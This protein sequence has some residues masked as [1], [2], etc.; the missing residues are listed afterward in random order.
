MSGTRVAAI[1]RQELRT[2]LASPAFLALLVVIAAVTMTLNP[3]GFVRGTAQAGPHAHVNSV[4]AATWI[5]T[6]STFLIY[7]FFASLMAGMGILRDDEERVS[8]MIHATPLTPAEYVAGKLAGVLSALG[9]AIAAHASLVVICLEIVPRLMPGPAPG[10]FDAWNHLLPLLA[11]VV[12]NVVFIAVVAFAAGERTRRPLAVHAV[13]VMLFLTVA[14]VFWQW[15]PAWLPT[16]VDHLLEMA[17]PSALRWLTRD[18]LAVDRGAAFYN[19]APLAFGTTFFVN[20]LIV[21]TVPVVLVLLSI[22]HVGNVARGRRARVSGD[23][24]AVAAGSS[25]EPHFEGFPRMEQRAPGFGSVVIEIA[26]REIR[27][28]FAQPAVLLLIP[29]A[30]LLVVQSAYSTGELLGAASIPTAGRIAV[31][32][33]E[34]LTAVVFLL[35]M[36]QSVESLHRERSIGLDSIYFS[37]PF[38][39]VSFLAGKSLAGAALGT[40]ILGASAVAS[41]TLMVMNGAAEVW[42]LALVWGV[43]LAPTFLVWIG[44]MLAVAAI[45]R[46]R[47]ATYAVGLTALALTLYGQQRGA[48]T[49]A[50]NWPLWGTLR[51]SDMGVFPLDAGALLMNRLL[52][53]ATAVFL[54]AIAVRQFGRVEPDLAGASGRFELRAIPTAVR[55]LG[56]FAIAPVLLVALI[57]WQVG[58]GF[59]GDAVNRANRAYWRE[60]VATFSGFEVP[61]LEHVSATIDLEPKHR[62]MRVAG[63]YLLVNRGARPVSRLPVTTGFSFRDIAWRVDGIAA[64]AVDRAGLHVIDLPAP[65]L[66]GESMRLGFSYRAVYPEGYSRNGGSLHAFI[67]P[68]G[69]LLSTIRGEFLPVLGF[70]H[71]IGIDAENRA[72]PASVAP[73]FW[74]G[75]LDPLDGLRPFD[76][77]LE[78]SVPAAYR[79][80]SVGKMTSEMTRGGRT[81]S[82]W[83]TD[84]PVV[85]LQLAAGRWNVRRDG[86]NAVYFHPGHD[87]NAGE[88]LRT[89]SL[90][91]AKFSEWFCPYPWEELRIHEVPD[92]ATIATSFPTNVS[93][94]ESAGF[95]LARDGNER[96]PFTI[97]AHEVAHQWWGNLLVPGEG[98][99]ADVLT[100]SLAQ[101]SALLLRE[102][103]EGRAGRIAFLSHLEASYQRSRSADAERPLA[104][105]IDDA[106]G[107]DAT[108]IHDKGP[109]VLWMLDHHLGRARMLA[110]LQELLRASRGSDDHPALHDLIA[111]LRRHSEYPAEFDSLV[112]QWVFDVIVPEFRI[113][114]ASVERVNGRWRVSAMVTNIGGGVVTADVALTGTSATQATRRSARFVPGGSHRMEWV[115]GFAP[116]R[117]VVDPDR[118]LLQLRRDRAAAELREISSSFEPTVRR[119]GMNVL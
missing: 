63:T 45:V 57:S 1:A 39:T 65:L 84:H 81:T 117:I 66:P 112:D 83:E 43:V 15:S 91:R 34:V 64:R 13:A 97:T 73:D 53:L 68:A 82:V 60:N 35:L 50:W 12:P 28:L 52:M 59:Q 48:M 5:L 118:M 21:V 76:A 37:L 41:W 6:L 100:E 80:T 22:R 31:G 69:A 92:I 47:S 115:V 29:L 23:G 19:V 114:E 62:R 4:Y 20:R 46:S 106:S 42:P 14:F 78:I 89:L 74:K 109:W 70:V 102:H 95:L 18:L 27:E 44:F 61:R 85:A 116:S 119:D 9:I 111:I 99:G 113:S 49:W 36:F 98:P 16:L 93:L 56:P 38:P 94:S 90:A 7:P 33:I 32:T 75:T 17:D 8:E 26:R 77:R 10:P 87:E 55:S 107:F 104:E 110:G 3:A 96:A 86:S 101:F 103:V 71:G 108:V 2:Q 11:I 25:W 72:K 24:G 40:V 67:L 58:R 51:W 79:V 105:V 30:V 88:I 54:A